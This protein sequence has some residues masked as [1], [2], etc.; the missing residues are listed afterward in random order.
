LHERLPTFEE[1]E[2]F[3]KKIHAYRWLPVYLQDTLERIPKDA[4]P[5]V[6]SKK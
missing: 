5:M 3:Q 4:V 6:R 1:A 2:V